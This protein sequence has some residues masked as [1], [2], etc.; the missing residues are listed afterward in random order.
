MQVIV[1]TEQ[2][3]KDILPLEQV[4]DS[5]ILASFINEILVNVSSNEYYYIFVLLVLL[6]PYFF[7]IITAYIAYFQIK[8]HF[9][10]IAKTVNNLK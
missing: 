10:I 8:I 1:S 3:S 2:S 7:E 4:N 6:R 5:I 9:C